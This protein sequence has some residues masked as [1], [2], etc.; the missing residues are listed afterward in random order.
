M[1]YLWHLLRRIAVL[2]TAWPL[3]CPV[4]WVVHNCVH[5]PRGTMGMRGAGLMVGGVWKITG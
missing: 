5:V 4:R 2:S 1:G 3:P